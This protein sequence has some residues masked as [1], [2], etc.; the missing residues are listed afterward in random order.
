MAEIGLNS[1]KDRRVQGVPE[2]RQCLI[3]GPLEA[4]NVCFRVCF[5]HLLHTGGMLALGRRA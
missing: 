2:G 4:S 3:L 5:A 1:L